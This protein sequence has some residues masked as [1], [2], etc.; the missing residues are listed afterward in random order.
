[1]ISKTVKI[2]MIPDQPLFLGT[3][4]AGL[5]KA[6]HILTLTDF[7]IRPGHVSWM[8]KDETGRFFEG[9]IGKKVDLPYYDD[10]HIALSIPV[11][12]HTRPNYS[13][14]FGVDFVFRIPQSKQVQD[15]KYLR[16]KF[17]GMKSLF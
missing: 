2:T 11:T 1:M 7:Q 9:R 17:P 13:A 10:S 14:L 6:E 8:I 4:E 3:F 16:D 5:P 12:L 15:V